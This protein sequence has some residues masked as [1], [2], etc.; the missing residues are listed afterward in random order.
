MDVV[1]LFDIME[2]IW[3]GESVMGV[4]ECSGMMTDD[5]GNDRHQYGAI[6]IN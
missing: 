6:I 5:G 3:R 4:I 1:F 2:L